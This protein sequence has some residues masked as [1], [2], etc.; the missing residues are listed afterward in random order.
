V[1]NNEV[2][3]ILEALKDKDPAVR[4]SAVTL[5]GEV[6]KQRPLLLQ[7][8]SVWRQM[9]SSEYLSNV[10]RSSSS[11]IGH[12]TL[13]ES[14]AQ[15]FAESYLHSATSN[16]NL[17]DLHLVLDF[18]AVV[19]RGLCEDDERIQLDSLDMFYVL[20]DRDISRKIMWEVASTWTLLFHLLPGHPIEDI[21]HDIWTLGLLKTL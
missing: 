21:L 10:L 12:P 4:G 15:A 20:M 18:F 5:L 8:L 7:H 9:L 1:I 2:P 14:L 13:P 3:H 16:G 6:S 19:C 17:Q 11:Y